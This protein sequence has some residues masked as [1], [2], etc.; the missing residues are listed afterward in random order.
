MTT[1]DDS[2]HPRATDGKFAIKEVTEASGGLTALAPESW[3][4]E[5]DRVGELGH[6]ISRADRRREG[7]VARDLAAQVRAD[8]PEAAYLTLDENCDQ[9]ECYTLH[10]A[11]VHD[12]QG[13]TLY[14]VNENP[15]Y[16]VEDAV[17]GAG[18]S[19]PDHGS[20]PDYITT[21]G[22]RREGY[23]YRFDLDA[24]LKGRQGGLATAD[25]GQS[26]INDYRVMHDDM[27][28]SDE[29]AARDMVTDL[30]HWAQRSGVDFDDLVSRAAEVG[31]DESALGMVAGSKS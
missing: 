4:S 17:A 23:S 14:D 22:T 27:D 20:E 9:P 3:R 15:R 12:S 26:V 8:V 13:N 31:R 1:Y 21:S 30:Y 25:R 18:L 28:L 24:A 5:S 10:L 16:T 29:T 19:E 6:L 2:Q 11:S 7:I